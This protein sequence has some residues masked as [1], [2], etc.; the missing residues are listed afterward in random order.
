[1]LLLF[2]LYINLFYI[3]VIIDAVI[4]LI[5]ACPTLKSLDVS[6][7]DTITDLSLHVLSA[8]CGGHPNGGTLAELYLSACDK[9]SP[10]AIQVLSSKALNL[11]LLVLDGCEGVLGTFVHALVADDEDEWECTLDAFALRMLAAGLESSSAEY[12]NGGR[13]LDRLSSASPSTMLR[14]SYRKGV[15]NEEEE[16][17]LKVAVMYSPAQSNPRASSMAGKSV[18]NRNMRMSFSPDVL[19]R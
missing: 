15:G 11:D 6:F 8:H 14:A 18:R 5:T 16:E 4:K 1:V 12:G 13:K 7:I 10:Q 19:E 9:L 17:K 2:N 3:F